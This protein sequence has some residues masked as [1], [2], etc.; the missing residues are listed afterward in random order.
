MG[1]LYIKLLGEFPKLLPGISGNTCQILKFIDV[2]RDRIIWGSCWPVIPVMDELLKNT[3]FDA[4]ARYARD[5]EI[6]AHELYKF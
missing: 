5:F 1:N 6:N 3:R 4:V 2:A